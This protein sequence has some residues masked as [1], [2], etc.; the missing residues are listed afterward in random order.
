[1]TIIHMTEVLCITQVTIILLEIIITTGINQHI[2]M[3]MII[4]Q[5]MTI[6]IHAINYLT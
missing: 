4:G 6:T 3:K 2:R 5:D 1:M